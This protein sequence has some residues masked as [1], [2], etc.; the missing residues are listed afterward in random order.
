MAT[1]NTTLHPSSIFCFLIL[2]KVLLHVHVSLLCVLPL[3]YAE[4]VNAGISWK[5][6]YTGDAAT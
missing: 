6:L 3:C 1:N 5:L 2:I 4:F